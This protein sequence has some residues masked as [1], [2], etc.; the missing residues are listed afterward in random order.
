MVA[1][2]AA[3]I[4]TSCSSGTD[5][6]PSSRDS[7]V[8]TAVIAEVAAGLE[9]DPPGPESDPILFIESFTPDGIDL[10]VQVEIVAEFEDGYDI[11]FVDER[12]E[13]IEDDLTDRPVRPGGALLGLGPIVD[14]DPLR[15]RVEVYED[16][17]NIRGLRFALAGSS[18]EGWDIAGAPEEVEPEG[19]VTSS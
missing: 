3:L 4:L 12:E 1:A 16:E 10:E 17:R 9:V 8:Y 6:E 19:F 7:Q 14:G 18:D 5:G 13:A 11:R 15:V 2:T